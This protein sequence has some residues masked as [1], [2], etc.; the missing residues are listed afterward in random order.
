LRVVDEVGAKAEEL[1]VRA[2]SLLGV[3]VLGLLAS[4]CAS[5]FNA[6]P[7]QIKPAISS[8]SLGQ[9]VNTVHMFT[10]RVRGRDKLLYLMER[11]RLC[12]IQ[13]LY[14]CSLRDYAA[15][16][17]LIEESSRKA[18]V[19]VSGGGA[20]LAAIAVNDNA[21]PYKAAGY[22]RIFL[23]TAQALNYLFS[24]NLEDACV[25][26]RL[27][28]A[29]QVAALKAHQR[30]MDSAS[31]RAQRERLSGV[32]QNV[33]A[34]PALAVMDREAGRV[35][36]SFQDA[37]SFYVSAIAWELRG[38]P[39]D[40]YID[41]KKAYELYPDNPYVKKD[42]DRLA[43]KLGMDEPGTGVRKA[44][45]AAGEDRDINLVVFFEEGFVSEKNE[46]KIP[47]PLFAAGTIVAAA[48]PVYSG[49]ARTPEALSIF[50]G[51]REIG[52]TETISRVDVLAIKALQEEM[53]AILVRQV[54][55]ATT[56]AVASKALH[57]SM[58]KRSND[59]MA[60]AFL[61]LGSILY[62][63]Y[64]ENADLRSWLTLPANAQILKAA[65]KPGRQSLS[66]RHGARSAAV[67]LDAP[68]G[69]TVILHVFGTGTVLRSRLA[70]FPGAAS[71]REGIPYAMSD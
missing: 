54:L 16:L 32:V 34:N 2:G 33:R 49:S 52:K 69:A 42:L 71:R 36:N 15:A 55:R 17:D 37:Y 40:A 31:A 46:V 70:V 63:L 35:K 22:E 19:S 3:L 8:L 62:N 68:P 10:Q 60:M 7:N 9:S 28:H 59:G 5:T 29:A 23:H 27:A 53:P 64:S 4:G 39:N 66:L 41:Y 57:D 48:L 30:E 24:T 38:E 13:G 11:G 50:C 25:E 67:D 47:I 21:I 45:P 61:G 56:K 12:Q 1:R 65:L 26:V 6:Y 18:L 14:E 20:Q 44:P 58:H 51:G 43:L